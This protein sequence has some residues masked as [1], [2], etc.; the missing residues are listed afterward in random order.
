[1]KMSNDITQLAI[2]FCAVQAK[3]QNVTK[4]QTNPFFKNNY[5]DL[6]II[7]DECRPLLS[8]NGLSMFQLPCGDGEKA[9]LSTMLMHVSGQ[10]IWESVTLPL[11]VEKG[12]SIA[13]VFGSIVTY[14]RRYSYSSGMCIAQ[15]DDDGNGAVKASN[16]QREAIK[17]LLE[18]MNSDNMFKVRV[19]QY[20]TKANKEINDLSDEQANTFL[21]QKGV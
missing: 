20:L 17:N 7:L 18:A 11:G 4:N 5:A 15:I 2:A 1:M 8:E 14:L 6:A 16:D 13:Q 9:G 19:L 3:V 21:K 10:Y 12:K